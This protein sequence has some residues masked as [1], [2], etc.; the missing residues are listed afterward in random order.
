MWY[1]FYIRHY[2]VNGKLDDIF[3]DFIS[4]SS[5]GKAKEKLEQKYPKNNGY[6]LMYKNQINSYENY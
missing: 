3:S 6:L 2:D 4:E 5:V 1:E